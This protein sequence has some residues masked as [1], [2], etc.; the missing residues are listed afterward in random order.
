ML[1]VLSGAE[2]AV[3]LT[4]EDCQPVTEPVTKARALLGVE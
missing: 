2:C 3:R 4:E 1:A